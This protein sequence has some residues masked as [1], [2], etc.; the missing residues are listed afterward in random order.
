[1][2]YIQSISVDLQQL[3]EDGASADELE[4]A[5]QI[6]NMGLNAAKIV[7]A[8]VPLLM[9]YPLLQKYLITGITIGAVKG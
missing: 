8:T 5:A 1:M 6:N 7:V 4:A 9:I 3:V 2:S